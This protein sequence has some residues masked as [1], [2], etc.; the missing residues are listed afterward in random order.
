[1]PRKSTERSSPW[2][3]TK[4]FRISAWAIF[5]FRPLSARK[6]K[7]WDTA[8]ESYREALRMRRRRNDWR[9][10]LGQAYA[11]L[12]KTTE[13]ERKYREVLAFSADDVD[14]LKGL[15]AAGK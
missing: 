14:A 5:S 4:S 15:Q 2:E 12:G 7:R 3:V 9:L 10:A 6:R 1:M 8:A 13:A 11:Q